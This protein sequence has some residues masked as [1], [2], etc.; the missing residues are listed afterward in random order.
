MDGSTITS[1]SSDGPSGA[2]AKINVFP[3]KT[4]RPGTMTP[5]YYRLWQPETYADYLASLEGEPELLGYLPQ[6]ARTNRY[7][8]MN[9]WYDAMEQGGINEYGLTIGETTIGGRQE[10]V[11]PAGLM[12]AF[13]NPE[14][15]LMS[16]ALARARTAR[17]AI[18]VMGSLAEEYGYCQPYG[19]NITINDGNEVW[20]FEIYGPGPDWAPGSDQPGAVWCAQRIPDGEVSV[21]ANKSRIGEIEVGN[22]EYFLYSPNVF[23]LAKDMGWWTGDPEHPYAD[24]ANP[25]IFHQAYAPRGTSPNLREWAV[26]NWVAPSLHLDPTALSWPFSVV[27]D[28]EVSV[29]DV[30][31]IHRDYYEGY[32]LPTVYDVTKDPKFIVSGKLSPLACP[33][34][35]DLLS[36]LGI[37]ALRS[38]GWAN[39]VFT[40][41]SQV[42]SDLPDPIKGCMWFC[43]GLAATGC[44]SPIYS[45]TT[46]LP[47]SWGYTSMTEVDRSEAYWAFLLTDRLSY[48]RFQNAIVDIRAVRD[49]AEEAFFSM[50]DQVEQKVVDLYAKH[51]KGAAAQTQAEKVVTRYT[52]AATTAVEGGYWD[53]VDYLLF[54]YHYKGDL[55]ELNQLPVIDLTAAEALLN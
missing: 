29:Q 20:V 13:D 15:S 47:A 30:M 44:Y 9:V 35:R 31:A 12:Y 21:Y 2:N 39:S 49:P 41:V 26:L 17:E 28:A 10:L 22:P 52:N 25:F 51:T 50:Q 24:P 36:L 6:V 42:R 18:D 16:L 27:P 45:G 40:Y 46:E 54:R 43:F 23:S 19:E 8:G 4:Y 33:W 53:L 34:N 5:I 11:N 1:Y 14:N 7:V 37:R 55:G 32:T 48:A 3:A 38:V